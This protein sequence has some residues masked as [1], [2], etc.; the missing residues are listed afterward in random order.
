[1]SKT[2]KRL[3]EYEALRG[4]SILLLLA[5][6]SNIFDPAI[7]G[8]ALKDLGVFVAS[9]LLGSF[10]FLAGYFTEASI[11]KPK[12]TAFRFAWS[13]F[14]RIF[15]PYWAALALF[16]FVMGVTLK[17]TDL[18][19]Y[20]LNLQAVFSPV[21]VKPVLTLWYISMLVVFYIVYGSV[22]L[23]TRSM[24]GIFVASIVFYFFALWMHLTAGYFD[25]R[26]FQYF[27]IF[28]M[29]ALF[30][31]FEAARARLFKLNILLKGLLA[32]GSAAWLRSIL[33]ADYKM[34]HI[35]YVSAALFFMLSWILLLLTLF[36]T[37]LGGWRVWGWLSI[38][39]F[40]TYLMHRPIWSMIDTTF[41]LEPGIATMLIHLIPGAFLSLV[42][43][44]FLQRGYDRLLAFLR[45]K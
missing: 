5:L 13:K 19:V 24:I 32:L 38:A 37:R 15:P 18:L 36:Q 29:G 25:P 12:A 22:M 8:E 21:F 39:S 33:D 11:A 14:I 23:A 31:R 4:V 1:M 16:I 34:T 26:F 28:L 2:D 41:S 45:L 40:F 7:F 6:H 9:L 17:Q 20:L 3:N 42:V 43:G 30:C 27:F 35:L 44:Y 10:F